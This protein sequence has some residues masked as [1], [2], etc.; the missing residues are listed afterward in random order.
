MSQ[1]KVSMSFFEAP[2]DWVIAKVVRRFRNQKRNGTFGAAGV[3]LE[4]GEVL[5]QSIFESALS[6]GYIRNVNLE[7]GTFEYF[8]PKA[9]HLA[10][11]GLYIGDP[12]PAKK[13]YS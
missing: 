3:E 12:T 1:T 2:S 7:T 8:V 13:I 11:G 10:D 4:S 5:Y 6:A 9:L